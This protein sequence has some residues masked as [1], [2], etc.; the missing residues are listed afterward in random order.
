[1]IFPGEDHW[2]AAVPNIEE[3]KAMIDEKTGFNI[4]IDEEMPLLLKC[5]PGK[6]LNVNEYTN[7]LN[8]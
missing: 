4:R 3:N 2:V 6:G 7:T 5:H 1:M 8:N